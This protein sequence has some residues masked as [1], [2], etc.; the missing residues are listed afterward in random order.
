MAELKGKVAV[1]TAL[2]KESEP[3]LRRSL[4][5]GPHP[6]PLFPPSARPVYDSSPGAY[7]IH[8]AMSAAIPLPA[9]FGLRYR[10]MFAVAPTEPGLQRSRMTNS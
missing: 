6:A 7:L 4:R 3:L 8:L 2:Q 9:S 10:V 1:V 5:A